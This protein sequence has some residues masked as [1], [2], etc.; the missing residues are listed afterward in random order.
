MRRVADATSG[1]V[2]AEYAYDA[3]G[4]ATRSDTA[5]S[6]FSA[7]HRL[8][9]T[10]DAG[11]RM[12]TRI[13][14][15]EGGQ[16][17]AFQYGGAEQRVLKEVRRG[18]QL[19]SRKLY[20]HGTSSFP[21][22]E[23]TDDGSGGVSEVLYVFGP[24][25]LLALRRGGRV[26]AVMKD[27]LGSTRRLVTSSGEVVASY[28][29]LSFGT[30]SRRSELEAGL[31]SYLYTGHEYDSEVGLYNFRA[32]FYSGDLG[33]FLA[34]DP[35]QQFFSPYLYAA[36]NPVLYIDP[37]GTFSLGSLFSAIGGALIGAVEILIG[38]AVDVVAAVLGVVTGGLSTPPSIALASLAGVFY[39]AGVSAIT[40]SVFNVNDFSWK[41]YGI[42]MGI[43]AAVGAIS[44]GFGS[45]GGATAEFATGVQAR[46]QGRPAGEHRRAR[47]QLP[48][49]GGLRRRRLGGR[50]HG[51]GDL[52]RPGQWRDPR[53]GRRLERRLERG[54]PHPHQL[55]PPPGLQGGLGQPGQ[56]LHR[57]LRQGGGCRADG[58]RDPERGGGPAL[59]QGAAPIRRPLRAVDRAR[60]AS[61]AGGHDAGAPGHRPSGD[62]R[63]AQRSGVGGHDPLT[64]HAPRAGGRPTNPLAGS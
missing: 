9:L 8:T 60:H 54:L 2:L 4:N 10:Y 21:L 59:G 45:L 28:D 23:A 24:A 40:Y 6:E 47:R 63:L 53:G 34:V 3:N 61:A 26:L 22:Y 1:A 37:S 56:A 51:L 33:R 57:R 30:P 13:D 7:A 49:P 19:L 46:G 25:G 12:T 42:Q 58:Q 38:V 27:H 50:G 18:D 39:G 62:G 32:R 20:V 55:H 31:L 14:D 35:E 48:H 44:F 64:L 11:T 41:D 43:G 17:L 52:Q 15:A 5:A 36:N 16:T 29:Y